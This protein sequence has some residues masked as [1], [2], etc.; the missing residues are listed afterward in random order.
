MPKTMSISMICCSPPLRLPANAVPALLVSR[1]SVGHLLQFDV[2]RDSAKAASEGAEL[3]VFCDRQ[4]R[5][6]AAGVG[7]P[8]SYGGHLAALRH[9][10]DQHPLQVGARGVHSDGVA[11]PL[12]EVMIGTWAYCEEDLG[13]DPRKEQ[14]LT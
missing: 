2:L 14:F 3:E 1:E 8:I 9:A 5:K 13:F 4:Q 7:K 10:G 11:G 12:P 6:A